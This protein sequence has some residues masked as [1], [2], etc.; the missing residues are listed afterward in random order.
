MGRART[1]SGKTAAFVLPILHRV[2]QV[3]Y[4]CKTLWEHLLLSGS[5]VGSNRVDGP[6]CG[7]HCTDKGANSAGTL[8]STREKEWIIVIV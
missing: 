6:A 1:G 7:L 4:P 2:V 5:V 8:Q 3:P